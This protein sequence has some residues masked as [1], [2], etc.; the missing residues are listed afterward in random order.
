MIFAGILLLAVA[1]A[2][3]V[4]P[5]IAIIVFVVGFLGFLVIYGMSGRREEHAAAD[6]GSHA[7]RRGR[8]EGRNAGTR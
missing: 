4:S 2:F 7:A 1:I 8:R 3:F 6:P 5:L